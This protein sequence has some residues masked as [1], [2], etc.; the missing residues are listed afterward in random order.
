MPI[1]GT[2]QS[3][4]PDDL[5][6]QPAVEDRSRRWYALYTK[7]RQEKALARELL[8]FQVPFYLPLVPKTSIRRG[9]RSTSH[10]PLFTGYVFLF[11]DEQER[12]RALKTNRLSRMLDVNDGEQ[13]RHDL[14]QV[15]QLIETDAP[16]TVEQRLE[17]GDP[18]R[19]K[20]G[21]FAGVEGVVVVRRGQARLLIEV[22]FLQQGASVEIEDFML[23]PI[24]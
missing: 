22:T 24:S 1:L 2:E 19:V 20:S 17:P 7:A 3:V 18:V 23:E 10:V 15:K 8:R 9:R 14:R 4:F 11:G 16:L 12:L 5:L 21:P 13:L 6:E